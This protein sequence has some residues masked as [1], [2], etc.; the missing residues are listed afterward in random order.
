MAR[1]RPPQHAVDLTQVEYIPGDDDSWDHERLER[2]FASIADRQA[3]PFVQ[4]F[5]GETRYSLDAPTTFTL[6]TKE[7]GGK[8]SEEVV[9]ACA[10]D[11]VNEEKKPERWKIRRIDDLVYQY[12]IYPL[13]Q[14][15]DRMANARGYREAIRRGL[16]GVVDGPDLDCS[17]GEDVTTN[18]LVTIAREGLT[19][20]IGL[21]IV[22][23]SRPL[24]HA[25]KKRFAF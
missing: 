25:E 14:S 10:R 24:T 17:R 19:E 2:E 12:E 15:S 18:D 21:A 6:R 11:Y 16:V 20:Q 8:V 3:H 22:T 23:I 4:Y 9:T 1:L 13:I 7:K 5:S